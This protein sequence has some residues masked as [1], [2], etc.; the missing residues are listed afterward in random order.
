MF[1]LLGIAR[2]AVYISLVCSASLPYM[3]IGA[4]VVVA[5]ALQEVDGPPDAQARAQGNDEGLKDIDSGSEK[6]HNKIAGMT[7]RRKTAQ[8]AFR[9]PA[10]FQKIDFR[11]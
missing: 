8:T 3:S 5:V 4:G 6:C 9:I 7:E 1:V 11:F 2:A 10:S